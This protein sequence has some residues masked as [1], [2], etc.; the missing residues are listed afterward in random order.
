MET[1]YKCSGAFEKLNT[2]K[3]ARLRR[4]EAAIRAIMGRPLPIDNLHATSQ[5]SASVC[6]VQGVQILISYT[7]VAAYKLPDGSS[8]ATEINEFSK[9]TDRSIDSFCRPSVRAWQ[10]EFNEMLKARLGE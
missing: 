9:T 8:V 6:T 3:T 5:A 10:P 1:K 2:C 4:A 7:T